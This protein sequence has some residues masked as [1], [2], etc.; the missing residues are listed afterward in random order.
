[1]VEEWA[2]LAPLEGHQDLG[3]QQ[4]CRSMYMFDAVSFIL[5]VHLILT[6]VSH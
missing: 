6:Y 3:I 4:M 1:M 2:D 5:Y